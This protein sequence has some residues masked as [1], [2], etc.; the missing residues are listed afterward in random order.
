MKQYDSLIKAEIV[1]ANLI[2][3]KG[4]I[5]TGKPLY[6]VNTCDRSGWNGAN[7]LHS[8]PYSAVVLVCD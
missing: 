1:K 3:L 5:Q 6:L 2:A 4:A 8:S 7:F